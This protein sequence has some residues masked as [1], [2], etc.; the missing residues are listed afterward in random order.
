MALV[1]VRLLMLLAGSSRCPTGL[2]E[3]I[4]HEHQQPKAPGKV[5]WPAMQKASAN[6]G[7]QRP[8][9]QVRGFEGA[10]QTGPCPAYPDY[11]A[12]R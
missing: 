12:T 1:T 11:V 4:D 2:E 6:S 8:R 3:K 7:D 10:S 9:S 5:H